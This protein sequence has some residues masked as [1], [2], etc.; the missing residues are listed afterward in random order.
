MQISKWFTLIV[1]SLCLIT[2]A[3]FLNASHL[4]YMAAILLTLP[5]LSFMLGWGALKG[6]EFTRELPA[7][8]WEGEEGQFIYAARNRTA[9]TR[10]FI[11]AHEALPS[12]I[13]PL[14]AEPPLFN[15]P[16]QDVARVVYRVQF[17]RRGVYRVHAFDVTATDPLGVFAFTR[18]V[19]CEGELIVYPRPEATTMVPISGSDRYGWQEFVSAAFRGNSVDPDGVRQYTDGD[20]LRR[21]HWR[22]TA[23]TGKLSV[24]EFEESQS[25]S[26][27]IALDLQRGTE[28][29]HGTETTLEY[30]VRFAASLA[31]QAIQLGASVQLLLPKE[32]PM[33]DLP[34]EAAGAGLAGRGEDHL[35]TLLE[36]LA[37]VEANASQTVS[38]L[39][40]EVAAFIPEG[41]TLVILTS[42]ADS[43]LPGILSRLS[44]NGIRVG[45]VF[46]DPDSFVSGRRHAAQSGG[47]QTFLSATLAA[48]AHLFVLRRQEQ[49]PLLSEAITN[50]TI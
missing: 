7:T 32:T 40:G 38:G 24:I 28:V 16:A 21:I 17:L 15:V 29:G 5:A 37:R 42:R 14:E 4:Y 36:M 10:F 50:V 49:G 20:P 8:A 6:V 27:V 2:V 41:T 18:Q 48:Q 23:R 9:F 25:V 35:F 1:G 33:S 13:V 47:S 31:Q 19:P 43:A 12:W 26:L 22:Q 39:L 30:A 3:G 34:S 44:A 46:I 45:V 11:A